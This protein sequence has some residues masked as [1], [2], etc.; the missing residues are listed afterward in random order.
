MAKRLP[1]GTGDLLNKRFLYN[2]HQHG[3]INAKRMRFCMACKQVHNMWRGDG[4]IVCP[5]CGTQ[6]NSNLTAPRIFKRF[7]IFSGRRGG[8]TLVGAIGAREEA[9]I[10]NTLGWVMGP[11]FKVL[12]DSTVPTFMGLIPPNWVKDWDADQMN[13]TL[14]NNSKVH[15]R[16]L[17]DPER[18]RGPGPHWGWI[19]EAAQVQVR[20]WDVFR[21]SLS[22]HAGICIF[23]T[24]VLGYDWTY[25]RIEKPALV[26]NKPGFWAVR[27]RTIDNPI[28]QD[29]PVLRME[30]DEA[31]DSMSE[32]FFAQEYLGERRNFTG[33][34][35]GN[36]VL[37]HYLEDDD[38]VRKFIPEWPQLDPSRKLIVGLDSGA[39]H[40]FGAVL[41]VVTE[42]GLVVVADY[43]QRM[44]AISQQLPAIKF[45]FMTKGFDL[46]QWSPQDVTWA[47]NKNEAN[48]RLEF[49]LLGIGVLPA[50]NKHEIGIQRVHS[51]YGHNQLYIAHTADRTYEQ[52]KKYRWA[53]N[54]SSDGQQKKEQV[55]KFDDELPDALRY[56]VMAWPE[57]PKRSLI[58]STPAELARWNA[59]DQKTRWE[60]TQLREASARRKSGHILPEDHKEYPHGDFFQSADDIFE[61]S[62]DGIE[63][64]FA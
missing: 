56:G 59:F 26:Q 37:K 53:E 62:Q 47:A 21:P 45:E 28:F 9:Q 20:A 8:K 43:L 52:M 31:R 10:P 46:S 14:V 1:P 2:K 13:L 3:F 17:D 63:D 39:D 51:W 50:E 58:I 40:P 33:A 16:T 38:A 4:V 42:L 61:S 55:F 60:I 11:T 32:D 49:G 57:L 36:T 12:N 30:V 6:H 7:G 27:Y 18:A 44:N 48:L 15:F 23:T 24:T 54:I 35:Y 34:I 64:F 25:D 22:E 29:D 19:D 41:I 5:N